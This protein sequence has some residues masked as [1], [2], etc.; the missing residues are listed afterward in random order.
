MKQA[1]KIDL[2][3]L[4]DVVVPGKDVPVTDELP[5][6]LN[7]IQ[8]KALQQQIEK[9]VQARLETALKKATQQAVKDLKTHLS[10]VLPQLIKAA[11]K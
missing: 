9:I 3:V 10:K 1:E 4:K 11:N 6:V 7:E 2:P 8:A 5:P